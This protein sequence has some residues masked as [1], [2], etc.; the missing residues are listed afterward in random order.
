MRL[1]LLVRDEDEGGVSGTGIVAQGVEFENGKCAL[2]WLTEF[3][4]VAIYDDIET[5][6]AIHGHNGKTTVRWHEPSS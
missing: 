2:C 6:D 3:S 4:S 1:F 5:L